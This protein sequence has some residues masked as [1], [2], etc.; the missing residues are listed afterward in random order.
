VRDLREE[1]GLV[2][3][4]SVSNMTQRLQGTFYISAQ[5]PVENLQEWKPRS[6]NTSALSRQ[7]R[8]QRQSLPV[9]G[10]K[11]RTGLFGNETPSERAGLYGYYQSMVGDLE[12]TLITQ[13]LFKPWI[14]LTS[15]RLLSSIYP[16]A[17]GIV[18][19][20]PAEQ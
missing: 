17:Y 13:L 1:R 12:P 18:V 5:L 8:L 2:S 3:H 19:L 6:R 9:C 20:K 4:I 7:N 10:R 15:S 14:P 11:L 16:D